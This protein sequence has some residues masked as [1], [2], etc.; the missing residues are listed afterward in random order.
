MCS[1]RYSLLQDDDIS[2]GYKMLMGMAFAP[3]ERFVGM[4]CGGHQTMQQSNACQ[5][6][7]QSPS[8]YPFPTRVLQP[9]RHHLAA[10]NWRQLIWPREQRFF[11]E[12]KHKYV[13]PK[14]VAYSSIIGKKQ[15]WKK[16]KIVRKHKLGK[17]LRK[18]YFHL[19][20]LNN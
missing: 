13:L 11:K 1:D 10:L 17:I 15:S 8:I 4:T 5:H 18:L 14:C 2:R 6:N 16:K 20:C 7:P 3:R 9:D 19:F 12:G